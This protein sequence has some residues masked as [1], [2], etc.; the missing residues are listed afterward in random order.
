MSKIGA[1]RLISQHIIEQW[2]GKIAFDDTVINGLAKTY[3]IQ[4]NALQNMKLMSHVMKKIFRLDDSPFEDD[5]L[6]PFN[7][8]YE[9]KKSKV[10]DF[11][12]E[13]IEIPDTKDMSVARVVSQDRFQH[14][15]MCL[16]LEMVNHIYKFIKDNKEKFTSSKQSINVLT[17][18][19]DYMN[20]EDKI[21]EP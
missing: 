7:Q 6:I 13:L 14:H 5:V 16:S 11:Y 4:S 2:L 20:K 3:Y 8:L 18:D 1:F 9:R 21:L 15:S 19:I 17:N 10:Q 12:R